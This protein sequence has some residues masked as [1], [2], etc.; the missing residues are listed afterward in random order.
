[1]VRSPRL[2]LSSSQRPCGLS[3]GEVGQEVLWV[4]LGRGGTGGPLGGAGDDLFWSSRPL[5]TVL[6]ESLGLGRS[7]ARGIHSPALAAASTK[8]PLPWL[9]KR[10]LGPFS[11]SQKMSE[12]LLLRMGP[13]L[14]PRPPR[15]G[16]GPTVSSRGKTP[17]PPG[18][19]GC[20]CGLWERARG[21]GARPSGSFPGPH[22]VSGFHDSDGTEDEAREERE[23]TTL[24]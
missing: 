10:K 4:V 6:L 21:G 15:R 23:G 5:G 12:A 13:T 22:L 3:H 20:L 19:W 24:Y 9:W 16:R 1:M 7:G 18:R 14:T 2:L 17:G 11:L 8:V